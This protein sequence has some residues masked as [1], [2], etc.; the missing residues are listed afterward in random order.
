MFNALNFRTE[1]GQD[2]YYR[3]YDK[4]LQMWDVEYSE[5]YIDTS[6][7]KSHC[8]MIGNI[9]NPPLVLLHAACCGSTIWYPNVKALSQDYSVYAVD[10]ITEA[11][12]STLLKPIK[13]QKE[14]AEWLNETIN[15]LGIKQINLCGL[16]IGGWN[17]ANYASVY[18]QRVKKLILLSPIQIFSKIYFS[19]FL[20]LMKMGFKPT[21]KSVEEYLGWGNKKEAS[22]PDSVIEQFAISAININPN[23][24][25][26]KMLKKKALANLKMPVL[27][28]FGENEYA[29]SIKRAINTAKS[30]LDDLEIETVGNS[31]HLISVSSP[32]FIN[33][34]ILRFLN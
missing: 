2:D 33:E 12:K 29:F 8:L 7:G 21:R 14:C 30:I 24:V 28:L 22:L 6:F 1:K 9:N 13:N 27:V 20:K 18:P 15:G 23:G 25:F 32:A 11:S 17:A 10:L 5:K 26:P 31:S 4:S 3:A 34:R 19:Y 16:S